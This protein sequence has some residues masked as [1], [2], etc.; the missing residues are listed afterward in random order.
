MTKQ[1]INNIVGL[2][3]DLYDYMEARADSIDGDDG[4]IRP[5][6]EMAFQIEIEEAIEQLKPLQ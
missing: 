3:D 1:Q 6:K 5:N 4:E 2:L